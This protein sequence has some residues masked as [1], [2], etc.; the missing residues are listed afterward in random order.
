MA[1]AIEGLIF[2]RILNLEHKTSMQYATTV[3]LLSTFAGWLLFFLAQSYLP[4]DIK[5]QLISYIFYE[6]FFLDSLP[7]DFLTTLVLCIFGIYTAT[8]FLEWWGLNRLEIFLGK[9]PAEEI[10]EAEKPSG[11]RGRKNQAIGP[12]VN[13]KFF[14]IFLGN[15]CSFSVIL[16]ILVIRLFNQARYSAL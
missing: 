10:K 15:A 11:F 1:I 9:I 4:S 5:L 6:R 14:A 16:L 3:N 7:I 13:S 12:K 2:Y 8:S